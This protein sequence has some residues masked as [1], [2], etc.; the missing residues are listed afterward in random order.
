[1]FLS[2]RL[3]VLSV[4]QRKEGTSS[5]RPGGPTCMGAS[6]FIYGFDSGDGDVREEDV[7]GGNL[8]RAREPTTVIHA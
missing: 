5:L 7:E 1:M 6:N 4:V 2:F 8:E 3:P